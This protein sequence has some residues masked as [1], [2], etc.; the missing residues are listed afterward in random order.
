M[1]FI[2]ADLIMTIS[3]AKVTSFHG[4]ASQDRCQILPQ[5]DLPFMTR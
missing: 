5:L 2:K 1:T 3:Y 4:A